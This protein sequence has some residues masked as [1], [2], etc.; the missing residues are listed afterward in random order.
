MKFVR[1]VVIRRENKLI[2][3]QNKFKIYNKNFVIFQMI[4]CFSESSSKKQKL[5]SNVFKLDQKEIVHDYKVSI[6]PSTSMTKLQLSSKTVP[7]DLMFSTVNIDADNFGSGTSFIFNFT[8]VPNGQELP[9]LVTNKHVIIDDKSLEKAQTATLLFHN[10]AIDKNEPNGDFICLRF[11]N[12]F[13]K[14]WICHPTMDLCVMPFLKF[15]GTIPF[16][17]SL[18]E[19]HIPTIQQLNNLSAMEEILMVGYPNGIYDKTNNFPI[20]RRGITSTHPACDYENTP[21]FLIDVAAF[22][23]SSGSPVCIYNNASYSNGEELV[24][25]PRFLFL[26]ILHEEFRTVFDGKVLS[27]NTNQNKQDIKTETCTTM[28]LGNVIKSR[29]LMDFNELI[30]RES[31]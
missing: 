2:F 29:I 12:N 26:G 3:S 17:K 5:E 25:C 24:L 14:Y 13:H 31:L 9:C 27:A 22:N 21:N 18:G 28:H 30:R 10:K 7:N 23:G 4:D 6:I 8:P 1:L 11:T 15:F 20:F 19:Q 16:F